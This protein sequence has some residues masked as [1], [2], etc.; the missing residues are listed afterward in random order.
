MPVQVQTG[1]NSPAGVTSLALRL[2][3]TLQISEYFPL[4]ETE[5]AVGPGE[6][7]AE[8]R[9]GCAAGIGDGGEGVKRAAGLLQAPA[10]GSLPQEKSRRRWEAPGRPRR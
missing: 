9:S 7:L 3:V 1:R 10:L 8:R 5:A 4:P 6:R 2:A